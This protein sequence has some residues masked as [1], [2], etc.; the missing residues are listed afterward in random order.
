MKKMEEIRDFINMLLAAEVEAR[1]ARRIPDIEQANEK[2]Q[3]LL[4]FTQDP[5]IKFGLGYLTMPKS[6]LF[7]EAAQKSGHPLIRKIFKI[8]HYNNQKYGDFYACYLSAPEPPPNVNILGECFG[9]AKVNSDFKV[10]VDYLFDDTD[11][12][13]S[14]WIFAGG[15]EELKMDKLGNVV[16]ILRLTPP[17]NDADSLAEYDKDR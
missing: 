4:E 6:T 10:V 12:L 16:E 9:I 2:F 5:S 17:L 15:D 1:L 8:S 13:E 7:Y 3:D 11:L 14:S